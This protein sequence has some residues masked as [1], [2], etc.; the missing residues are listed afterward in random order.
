MAR[1]PQ[2]LNFV[3]KFPCL[4]IRGNNT[5]HHD[6]AALRGK[7]PSDLTQEIRDG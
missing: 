1:V 3:E 7:N 6:E 4:F 2:F 5:V